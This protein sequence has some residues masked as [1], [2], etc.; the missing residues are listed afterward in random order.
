MATEQK[1]PTSKRNRNTIVAIGGV[2]VIAGVLAAAALL[3]GL[4]PSGATTHP[5]CDELPTSEEVT[6]AL[7]A[8]HGLAEQ[9]SAQGSAITVEV[10]TPCS[11]APG[12]ALIE[13]GYATDKERTKI[14]RVLT[15]AEGF[16]V[17]VYV[18]KK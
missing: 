10:G 4:F 9:L 2:I 12:A 3:G 8:H 1:Q 6:S 16:G 13:V 14:D 7:E 18:V 5:P 17:P 15:D 11:D